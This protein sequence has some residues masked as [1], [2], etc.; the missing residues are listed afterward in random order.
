MGAIATGG[1]RCCCCSDHPTFV[2]SLVAYHDVGDL[3]EFKLRMP[4]FADP[5]SSSSDVVEETLCGYE[6]HILSGSIWFARTP[7][8]FYRLVY[9]CGKNGIGG[10]I[11]PPAAA[12][13]YAQ[14]V[15]YADDAAER[16]ERRLMATKAGRQRYGLQRY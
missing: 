10:G 9:R 7:V 1:Y 14:N 15:I 2:L 5:T 13:H 6:V 11:L 3:P 12:R 8:R 4:V 16:E